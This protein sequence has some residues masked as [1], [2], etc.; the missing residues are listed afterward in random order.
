M[1]DGWPSFTDRTVPRGGSPRPRRPKRSS[2]GQAALEFLF[3]LLF[4]IAL[5]SLLF[6]ALHFELDVFNKSNETRYRFFEKAHKNQHTTELGDIQEELEGE[7]LK[8]LIP[9]TVLFQPSGEI[10]NLQ[11]GPRYLRGKRGTEYW[12]LATL[13]GL[14]YAFIGVLVADHYEKTAG[15]V[16]DILGQFTNILSGALGNQSQSEEGGP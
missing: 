16:T 8:D 15:K 14:E 13:P 10:G 4:L 6:Q 3:A 9:Y 1:H 12:S 2:R 5:I 11:F 7:K